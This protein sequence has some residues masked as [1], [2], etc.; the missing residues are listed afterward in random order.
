MKVLQGRVERGRVVVD[1]QLPDG[2]AVAV[3][4]AGEEDGFELDEQQVRELC[5]SIEEADRGELIG[6][7]DVL[8]PH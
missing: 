5:V 3:V 7:D 6:L 8:K 1:E 2:A 4:L